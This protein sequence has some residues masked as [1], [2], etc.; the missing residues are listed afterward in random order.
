M[1]I[2]VLA[3]TFLVIVAAL[4]LVVGWRRKRYSRERFAFH[5]ATATVLIVTR[6]LAEGLEQAG[7]ACTNAPRRGVGLFGATRH[8]ARHVSCAARA[9]TLTP[10]SDCATTGTA[11]NGGEYQR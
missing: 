6:L 7:H 5:A 3:L 9:P 4:A 10:Q 2:L 1:T 8:V 11:L